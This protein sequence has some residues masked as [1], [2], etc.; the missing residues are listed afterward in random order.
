MM[1]TQT[2]ELS[3]TT[4]S[5]EN[6]KLQTAKTTAGSLNKVDPRKRKLVMEL[7]PPTGDGG[8]SHEDQRRA[9]ETET[10]EKDWECHISN[11]KTKAQ[12]STEITNVAQTNLPSNIYCD[13]ERKGTTTTKG[14]SSNCIIFDQLHQLVRHTPET[15]G[16]FLLTGNDVLIQLDSEHDEQKSWRSL[17][18][19]ISNFTSG[20]NESGEHQA[21]KGDLNKSF[22]GSMPALTAAALAAKKELLVI[23]NDDIE[24][25]VEVCETTTMEEVRSLIMNEFDDDMIPSDD[26]VFIVE[27]IRISTKQESRRLAKDCYGKTIRIETKTTVKKIG[28]TTAGIT[29]TTNN[30]D[31]PSLTTENP[32]PESRI[33]QT[34]LNGYGA[35]QTKELKLTKPNDTSTPSI[36]SETNSNVVDAINLLAIRDKQYF[37]VEAL[38]SKPLVH[39]DVQTLLTEYTYF[40]LKQYRLC[41]YSESDRI[42]SGTKFQRDNSIQIGFGGFQCIHCADNP[43]PR[44]FF[45]SN[46][47]NLYRSFSD[48]QGHTL[49]CQSCPKTTK[50]ALACLQQY[51]KTQKT[52]LRLGSKK[53]AMKSVWCRM[54]GE[55]PPLN[56]SSSISKTKR[57]KSTVVPSSLHQESPLDDASFNKA[58]DLLEAQDKAHTASQRNGGMS[59]LVLDEDRSW[60]TNFDFFLMK[61]FAICQF[62]ELDRNGR[63][64]LNVGHGGFQC[65]H[66]GGDGGRKFFFHSVDALRKRAYSIS[67]HMSSCSHC[68][69]HIKDALFQLWKNHSKEISR[70]PKA[71]KKSFFE[72]MWSRIHTKE[73]R[74]KSGS[75]PASSL[76]EQGDMMPQQTEG[77]QETVVPS[78]LRDIILSKK[79]STTK[80][81]G[82]E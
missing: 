71:S 3:A 82:I 66:C 38:S 21:Q 22:E 2:A 40:L 75:V 68:P 57:A 65:I 9:P 37:V 36:R 10:M 23:S 48:N 1:N 64:S 77:D 11:K 54:Q 41:Q 78:D 29:R 46:A 79:S 15:R 39:D 80:R 12:S 61:Q 5:K 47:E 73:F 60:L 43:R 50:D 62:T 25:S 31:K 19:M 69:R 34:V 56:L 63:A 8:S 52:T 70:L 27:G 49:A 67:E 6:T 33:Q 13:K 59:T 45:Y 18:K 14:T 26:W 81:K 58:I 7:Q 55:D 44:K 24:G 4:S 74:D 42:A 32:Q 17:S 72:R 53:D 76:N 20:N 30:E 28:G 51:N 35:K 16:S